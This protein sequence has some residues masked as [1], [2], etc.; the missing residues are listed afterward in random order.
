M[1]IARKLLDF[2]QA[3]G[4]VVLKTDGP[5]IRL[6]FLS[7]D[8]LRIR[9]SFDGAFKEASYVLTMTAWDDH[10]D[11]LFGEERNRVT[12]VVPSVKETTKRVVF[13]T[14]SLKLS[15]TKDPFGLEIY[16][17]EG[18]LLH[19][20]LKEKSYSQDHLGRVY[21]YVERE[22]DDRYY[23]FGEASGDLDKHYK[24]VRMAPKDALGYDAELQNC[25][26]K[27]IPFYIK[28]KG[29]SRH[30][31]G[32]FYHNL[33]PSEFD[34]GGEHSNYWH[35]YSYWVADKGDVDL[36]FINGP[37]IA[38]VVER[39]TDLTGKTV[40]PP[41]YSIGYLGSTMYYS[42]LPEKCDDEILGFIDKNN[43]EGIPV[44]GFQLSSGYTVGPDGLRYFFTWNKTRFPDPQGFFTRMKERGVMVSPN[45][46]PGILCTHPYYKDFD[47][48]D[49]FIKTA[50][51]T[52]TYIDR[53][54]GG[55]GSFM[56]F[57]NPKGRDFWKKMIVEN[58]SCHGTSSIWNDNCEYD[59]GDHMTLCDGDGDAR[60][61]GEV[62][63]ILPNLMS[64][65]SHVAIAET[66]PDERPY[67]IVRSGGP[68]IQRYAQ[69]WAGDNPSTW[70][71]FKYN[72]TMILGMG[73]S[74][75]ANHGADVGG[76]QGPSPEA[77]LL[78]RWVQNGIFMPRFSIHSCNTNNTV[79]EP[80]MY[81]QYTGTIREAIKLRY[82]LS[83]YL[84]SLIREAHE[85]GA[86]VMRPLV[87]EFQDDPALD[88]ESFQF[89]FGPEVMV[90]NVVEKGIKRHRVY[91]PAGCDWYEWGT[92]VRHAG[93]QVIEMDVDM[94]SIPM[95][96]REN[97][98]VPTTY[99]L[100]SLAKEQMEHLHLLVA[101]CAD[102]SF[103]LYEDDGVS[104]RFKNGDYLKTTINLKAGD[105]VTLS[106]NKV[107][108]YVSPI[109]D[110]VIDVINEKK[111]AFWV[112][113][114][115]ERIQQ[116]LD[117]KK[118][119]EAETGWIYDATISSVR[120]RCPNPSG[121][122]KV[123]ISFEDFDLIGMTLED[124]E[125]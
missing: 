109:R 48:A 84:Y 80:W 119:A 59:L 92:H 7:D 13:E 56:D 85:T 54:W 47:A 14:A 68:G 102:N 12:P 94:N 90:A 114:D 79:T 37:E 107:G 4:L 20:D 72:I 27:H 82:S 9:A 91:L 104:N 36:F 117:R 18:T 111:G 17:A 46:K 3:D 122:F 23:G 123:D 44:D 70:K 11:E 15:I 121:D 67:V 25:L 77:E 28:M 61:V 71:T 55:P 86:P 64:R 113:I 53:W 93:G 34:M 52:G 35:H 38:K 41:R 58:L 24:R 101:P 21:H 63:A 112:A 76:F 33:W 39:Y 95:F 100:F 22:L 66:S 81:E 87:Y 45:I 57:T 106:F 42:E 26:Y 30:A 43:E 97:A 96:L 2:T 1:K 89:M 78:V 73:L 103:T 69:T 65:M 99:G 74:G 29:G 5:D 31:V 16:D 108:T 118:W 75:V 125:E 88:N 19:K 124:D 49:A 32:L 98:I 60:P 6:V 62:K 40:M 120:I 116:Y 51:G 115:G 8:I 50:D 105:T 10:L 110:I 83:P